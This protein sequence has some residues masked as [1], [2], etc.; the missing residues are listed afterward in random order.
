MEIK[1]DLHA[2]NDRITDLSNVLR[3]LINDRSMCDSDT[4]CGVLQNYFGELLKHV[5][6]VELNLYPVLL[7]HGG[8]AEM[9]GVQNFMNGSQ[10]IKRIVSEYRTHWCGSS[11]SSTLRI[12]DHTLFIKETRQLFDL[13]L[14]R[15]Q[16]ENEKLY[17]LVWAKAA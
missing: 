16:D 17:P 8:E 14:D 11:T 12:K 6:T 1:S 2:A 15:L 7:N 13:V 3:Y 9:S 5:E 10:E 4:C